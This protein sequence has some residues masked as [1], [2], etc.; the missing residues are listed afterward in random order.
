[1]KKQREIT[2][3]E[4]KIMTLFKKQKNNNNNIK[5]M[6]RKKDKNTKVLFYIVLCRFR[7][8]HNE[9]EKNR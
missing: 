6:E 2:R 1:M 5:E 9:L 7:S 4:E 3:N 8:T